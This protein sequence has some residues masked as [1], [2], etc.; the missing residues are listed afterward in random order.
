MAI[1]TWSQTLKKG[2]YRDLNSPHSVNYRNNRQGIINDIE[3]QT[4]GSNQYL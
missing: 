3:K 2:I 1:S 4:T